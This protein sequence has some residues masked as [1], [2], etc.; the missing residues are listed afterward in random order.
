MQPHWTNWRRFTQEKTKTY[1]AKVFVQQ[2]H[3]SVD[4]LQRDELIVLVL[5]CTAEIQAGISETHEERM[6]LI[7]ASRQRAF[8]CNMLQKCCVYNAAIVRSRCLLCAAYS[9]KR[10]QLDKS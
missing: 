3:I 8:L 1:A 7:T 2:L 9:Y 5:H 10:E 4:D 6:T